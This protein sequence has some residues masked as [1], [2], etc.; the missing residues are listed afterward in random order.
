MVE[1]LVALGKSC[2][3]PGE[4]G[5]ILA[6]MDCDVA[7]F[8]RREADG[9]AGLRHIRHVF[10]HE[11]WPVGAVGTVFTACRRSFVGERIEVVQP[12][13]QDTRLA[14]R[15]VGRCCRVCA[16]AEVEHR[17]LRSLGESR[18]SGKKRARRRT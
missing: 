7:W 17:R 11:V 6:A 18:R 1:F 13:G 5:R 10:F 15:S 16:A 2:C 12:S 3:D 9:L 8:R 14:A 4:E